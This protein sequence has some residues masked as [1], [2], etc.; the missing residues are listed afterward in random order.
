MSL[1]STQA[2]SILISLASLAFRYP[3]AGCLLPFCLG[4]GQTAKTKMTKTG[5]RIPKGRTQFTQQCRCINRRLI[6]CLGENCCWPRLRPQSFC[7]RWKSWRSYT[8]W[9]A[10]QACPALHPSSLPS[11]TPNNARNPPPPERGIG[12]QVDLRSTPRTTSFLQTPRN[13]WRRL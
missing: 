13:Q 4:M 6:S 3:I 12:K 5:K 11:T 7:P 1:V 10:P 9:P 2:Y 8:R